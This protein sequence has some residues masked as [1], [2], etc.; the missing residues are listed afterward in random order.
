[1]PGEH[2]RARLA[3]EVRRN[4]PSRPG[5]YTWL[6]EGGETL[7]IGKSRNLRARMLSYLAPANAA[8]ESRMRLLAASLRGFRYR[9]TGSD[10]LAL[11][12][13]DALIKQHQPRHNTRQ[14]EDRERRYLLVTNDAFPALLT[15]E[16]PA[17]R[18][19]TLFGPFKDE[20]FVAELIALLVEEFGLRACR[21]AD[22]YRRSARYDLGLCP[23][24]CRG[25]IAP[26]AYAERVK[27][28]RAFL[29]GDDGWLRAVV[30]DAI[31]RASNALEYERAAVLV[32][33]RAFVSRFAA[34]Q[35]F[36]REWRTQRLGVEEASSGHRF[37]FEGG[38]LVELRDGE[39]EP[40]PVP[41]ELT[42]GGSD[43]AL[44]DR[45]M[46]VANA[47]GQGRARR[48]EVPVAAGA[49]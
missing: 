15:V 46:I 11:L 5:V 38:R 24:P 47:C 9:E 17:A 41:P 35:R 31:D 1:M 27:R 23:A 19:G 30:D 34:R 29:D 18:P 39:G 10:L 42:S 4:V 43:A 40:A 26:A 48:I 7:Y 25:A 6:G 33:R 21:D 37:W 14:R 45:A 20:Y 2:D 13:E 36:F 3:A 49:G 28:A 44:L 32:E 8:P 16:A 12:L 22:P